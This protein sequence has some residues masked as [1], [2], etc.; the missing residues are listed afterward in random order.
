MND[1]LPESRAAA[2]SKQNSD[3]LALL[4]RVR[5]GDREAFA[6]LYGLYQPR[7]YGYIARLLPQQELV[8]EVLDDVMFVVWTDCRKFRGGS[9]LS[10][11]I[12]GIAYRK[13]MKVLHKEL[14]RRGRRADAVDPDDIGREPPTEDDAVHR[15]LGQLS[16]EHRQVVVLTYFGGFAYKDIARIANCPVNTVK[17][18]MFY[19]RRAMKALLDDAGHGGVA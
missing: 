9:Q 3:E 13:S 16:P 18:R 2:R 6:A 14:R 11:W 19:A 7:L 4:L 8:E 15:A 10:T 5:L 1:Q 17:T 12:F